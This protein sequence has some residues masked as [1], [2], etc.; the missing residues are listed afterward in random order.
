MF[1]YFREENQVVKVGRKYDGCGYEYNVEKRERGSKNNSFRNFGEE[2]QVCYSGPDSNHRV[3]A[4]RP[5]R[6][7]QT[8]G[9]TT[10]CGPEKG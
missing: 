9:E 3:H 1:K 4:V 8:Q 6:V 5:E 7:L 2:N 10:D